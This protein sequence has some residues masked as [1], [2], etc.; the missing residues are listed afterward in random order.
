M[1]NAL[2]ILYTQKKYVSMNSKLVFGSLV[3]VPFHIKRADS[4]ICVHWILGF[5]ATLT[6]QRG[7]IVDK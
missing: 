2:L 3:L 4:H 1:L 6:R 5:E 7:E